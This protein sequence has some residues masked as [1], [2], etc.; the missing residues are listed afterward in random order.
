MLECYLTPE[1]RFD[2]FTAV[3]QW[4]R[5]YRRSPRRLYMAFNKRTESL[6]RETR[7]GDDIGSNWR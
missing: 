5:P 1:V 7:E 3:G 2:I 6:G 4:N